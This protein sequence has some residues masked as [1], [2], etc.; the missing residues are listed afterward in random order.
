MMMQHV[1][2]ASLMSRSNRVQEMLPVEKTC[3]FVITG[4]EGDDLVSLFQLP[5]GAFGDGIQF[6][7][8]P[9]R[10]QEVRHAERSGLIT[11]MPASYAHPNNRSAWLSPRGSCRAGLKLRRQFL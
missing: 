10:K 1:S 7:E 3:H 6:G 8:L 5:M 2:L 4:S 11:H 9:S